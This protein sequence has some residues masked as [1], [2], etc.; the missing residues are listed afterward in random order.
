[1][2]RKKIKSQFTLIGGDAV[3]SSTETAAIGYSAAGHGD[4]DKQEMCYPSPMGI[5]MR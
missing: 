4:I 1:V 2:N 5:G 3:S